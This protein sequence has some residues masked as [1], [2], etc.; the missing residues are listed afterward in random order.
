MQLCFHDRCDVDLMMLARFH[1]LHPNLIEENFL[2][3]SQDLYLVSHNQVQI[4]RDLLDQGIWLQIL[5][6]LLVSLNKLIDI[7]LTQLHHKF[8][9]ELKIECNDLEDERLMLV[10]HHTDNIILSINDLTRFAQKRKVLQI[11]MSRES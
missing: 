9:S 4:G 2:F 3:A 8:L 5:E 7:G 6:Y 1:V 11:V 10:S